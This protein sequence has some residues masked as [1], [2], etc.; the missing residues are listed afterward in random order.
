MVEEP[1]IGDYIRLGPLGTAFLP[2]LGKTPQP[3]VL[4]IDEIDKSDLDLP[5]DLL[6]ILEE[7]SFE[8]PEISRLSAEEKRSPVEV[9]TADPQRK[10]LIPESGCVAANA[11]PVI[12]M[13]SN[14]ERQFPPAFLRRCITL[15]IT[16]PS[17]DVLTRIVD[18]RIRTGASSHPAV[19]KLIDDFITARDAGT[20]A[21]ATDH[22]LNAAYL[23]LHNRW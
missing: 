21:G 23:V 8:I 17:K 14:D 18:Q 5:N 10:A 16:P 22:L 9:M 20:L 6:H 19:Q 11:F 4:L 12:F 7:C 1:K 2:S 15:S 3:R 13:T